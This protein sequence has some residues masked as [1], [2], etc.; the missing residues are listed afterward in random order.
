MIYYPAAIFKDK[1]QSNFGVIIPDLQGCYPVG[2]SIEEAISDARDAAIFHIEGIIAEGLAWQSTPSDINELRSR[3]EYAEAL[4]WAMIAV[5]ESAFMKQVR[6][7]VS[8]SEY[9]L[10]QV[11]NYIISRNETRSGFLAK[12]AQKMMR[13]AKQ[14]GYQS[15]TRHANHQRHGRSCQSKRLGQR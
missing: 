10:K 13:Q 4:L 6:F 15:P 3:P 1:E 9:L 14:T 2:D 11:D 5:D 12:A 7:N 8:W